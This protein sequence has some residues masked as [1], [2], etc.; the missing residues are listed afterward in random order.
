MQIRSKERGNKCSIYLP[1][2]IYK[3]LSALVSQGA[4]ASHVVTVSLRASLPEIERE[5]KR[6]IAAER[7][8]KQ[9]G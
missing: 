6:Q 1:A 5:I 4:Y 8:G 7:R 3:R 2:D 9:N